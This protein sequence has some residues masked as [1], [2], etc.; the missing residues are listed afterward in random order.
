M[1]LLGEM[2]RAKLNDLV[3]GTKLVNWKPFYVLPDIGVIQM[4]PCAP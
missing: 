1:Q 2:L 4:K 3:G